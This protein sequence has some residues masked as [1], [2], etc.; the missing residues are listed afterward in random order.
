MMRILFYGDSNTWGYNA[1]T[2]MRY[3]N[4]F[5]KQIQKAFPEDEILE[6]GLC[7]RTL[8]HSDP[9]SLEERNG[10][11]TISMVLKTHEPL[12]L[13]VIL[14]GTNDA[15]RAYGTNALTSLEKGMDL[16][17][18]EAMDPDNFKRS[19]QMP[20]FLMVTPPKLHKEYASCMRTRIHFGQEGYEMLEQSAKPL[21]KMA[22]KWQC[23]FLDLENIRAGK[24]DAIHLD[25]EG[26]CQVAEKLI[27]KLGEYR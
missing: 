22:D 9:Y 5:T 25:E 20:R 8:C 7:G 6:E 23:D 12:D 10:S 21:K 17:M 24:L 16:F 4:R 27:K 15:K 1:H 11:K 13:V 2:G 19:I 3:A 14:L 18:H 26:H